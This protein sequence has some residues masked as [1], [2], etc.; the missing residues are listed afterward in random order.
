MR[1]M[2]IIKNIQH[3]LIGEGLGIF[4]KAQVY[5]HRVELIDNIAKGEGY[6]RDRVAG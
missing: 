3:R 1:A 5:L 6:L 4:L 2:V